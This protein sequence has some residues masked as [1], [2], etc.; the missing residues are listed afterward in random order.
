MCRILKPAAE[1][2]VYHHRF[3]DDDYLD[4]ITLDLGRY[5]NKDRKQLPEDPVNS[6]DTLSDGGVIS[7]R[8]MDRTANVDVRMPVTC[9]EKSAFA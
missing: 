3:G 1:N 5:L 9:Y 2:L 6:S 7:S 8:L 4:D